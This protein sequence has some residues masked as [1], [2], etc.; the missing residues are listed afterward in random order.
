MNIAKKIPS[1]KP[2]LLAMAVLFAI[3]SPVTL[4]QDAGWYAGFNLGES[5]AD[6][7]REGIDATLRKNGFFT[8]SITNDDEDLAA[9]ILGGYSFNRF[10][11]IEGSYFNLGKFSS[12]T[13]TQRLLPP[14]NP[15]YTMLADSTVEGVGL[16]LVGTYPITERFAA[17]AR[18]GF[19]YAKVEEDFGVGA[20]TAFFS[21]RSDKDINEKY[22]LGLQFNLSDTFSLRTE[23]ERYRLDSPVGITDS[24]DMVSL[25]AV[26]RFGA[27]VRAAAPAPAPAPVAAAPAPRPAPAPAP[28]PAP[29]PTRITLSADALF[30][31]DS[32]E[33][34]TAGRQEMDQLIEDLRG[35]Q[36]EVLNVTGH[37]D[38]IG[39]MEYNL[40]L[41]QRRADSVRDYLIAN[42]IPA[43]DITARG[44]NGT[45]P[46]VPAN[47][48]TG[49]VNDA[50]KACL[51]PDRRVEVEVAALR[52]PAAP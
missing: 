45:Q 31:F 46:V 6:I 48:C 1:V 25:G 49:P 39:T 12:I 21:E 30:D 44:I 29:Q 19:N 50:L 8:N 14:T 22:G 17:F 10:F 11:A 13:Q 16:D 41:S 3:N 40:R 34:R 52:A 35:M 28:A 20:P 51:Q 9:K 43:G 2:S 42:G 7:E 38:R 32:A 37:T 18:V 26:F 15:A 24:V 23:I 5:S 27:P 47:Q 33:M 4:A 36:Y